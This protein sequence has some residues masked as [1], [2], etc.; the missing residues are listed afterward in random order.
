[1]AGRPTRRDQREPVEAVRA[2][3]QR[4][5]ACADR[6]QG[7]PPKDLHERRPRKGPEIELD[8]LQKPRQVGH[9]KEALLL[10]A[11]EEGQHG[12]IRGR[13]KGQTAA[14]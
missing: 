2:H 14:P 10:K 6:R 8:V 12:R 7:A 11:A 13:H 4:I 1:M 9:D 5:G 3:R